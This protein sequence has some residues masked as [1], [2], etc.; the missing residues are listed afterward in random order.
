[1]NTENSK[2]VFLSHSNKDIINVRV[3]RNKLEHN[4][5]YP[6]MFYLKCIE[7]DP[8]DYVLELLKREIDAR[9]RFVLCQSEN[10]LDSYW[11]KQE[12]DYIKTLNRPYEIVDLNNLDSIIKG[13]NRLKRRAHVLLS[14]SRTEYELINLLYKNGFSES[15]INEN[16]PIYN[17][18]GGIAYAQYLNMVLSKVENSLKTGYCILLIYSFE[19]FNK[20]EYQAMEN[21][22]SHDEKAMDYFIPVIMNDTVATP[23]IILHAHNLLDIRRVQLEKRSEII[24]NHLKYIDTLNNI[25]H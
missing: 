4:G 6:I 19:D 1:M 8:D 13:V 18:F 9:P 11:V 15:E 5:F 25:N 20:I 16:I 23:S 10:T 7:Q 24:I 17:Q 21:Y 14:S 3:V 2:W 22:I 12:V